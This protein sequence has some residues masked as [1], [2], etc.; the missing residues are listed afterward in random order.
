MSFF[1]YSITPIDFADN[2]L[3]ITIFCVS[4]SELIETGF[5]RYKTIKPEAAAAVMSKINNVK[6]SRLAFIK[7]F[8]GLFNGHGIINIIKKRIIQRF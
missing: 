4:A 1:S 5:K 2:P 3:E 8:L 7:I 6:I